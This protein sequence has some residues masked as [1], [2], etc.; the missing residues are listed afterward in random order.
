MKKTNGLAKVIKN[1]EGL[2]G[3]IENNEI[4][5]NVIGEIPS[6]VVGLFP[7]GMQM[8]FKSLYVDMRTNGNTKEKSLD[9]TCR[10][11]MREVSKSS[12][13]HLFIEMQ[14]TLM[15]IHDR[16]SKGS[17]FSESVVN[18]EVIDREQIPVIDKGE[19]PVPGTVDVEPNPNEEED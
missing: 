17:Y 10:S 7:L 12:V 6:S 15:S 11:L 13:S 19:F 5:K 18:E 16:V 9:L 4:Y 8:K 2:I 3:I 1:L 14:K